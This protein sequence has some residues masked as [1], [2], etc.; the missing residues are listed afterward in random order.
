MGEVLQF[1]P[2]AKRDRK[3]RFRARRE[4]LGLAAAKVYDLTMDHADPAIFIFPVILTPAL[5]DA[6]KE[7]GE[8]MTGYAKQELIPV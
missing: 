8:D 5:Y 7:M 2:S 6:A 1:M 4:R 3:E